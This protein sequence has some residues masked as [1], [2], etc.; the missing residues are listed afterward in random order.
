MQKLSIPDTFFLTFEIY[1]LGCALLYTI[2]LIFQDNLF[3]YA[4]GSIFQAECY[5]V[6][7]G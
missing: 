3:Y 1:I 5:F 4:L 2:T 6:L 7:V